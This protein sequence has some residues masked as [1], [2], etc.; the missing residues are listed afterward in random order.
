M[1]L[2]AKFGGQPFGI[3]LVAETAQLH[4]PHPCRGRLCSRFF[5]NGL[6]RRPRLDGFRPRFLA[7][8]DGWLRGGFGRLAAAVRRHR[9]AA[10]AIEYHGFRVLVGLARQR[11]MLADDL[12]F[13]WRAVEKYRD[14]EDDDC[15]QHGSADDA[16]FQCSFHHELRREYSWF[17]AGPTR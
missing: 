14:H 1:P 15:D 6:R 8:D 4:G 5:G 2:L 9:V 11:H 7:R 3:L 13:R 10:I 17:S 12:A 16:F